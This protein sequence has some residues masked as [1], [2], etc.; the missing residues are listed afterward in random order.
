[1]EN[2]SSDNDRIPTQTIKTASHCRQTINKYHV[3]RIFPTPTLFQVYLFSPFGEKRQNVYE[4]HTVQIRKTKQ[5]TFNMAPN[6]TTFCPQR[7]KR[8][9]SA[10]TV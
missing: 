3:P 5:K 8:I 2:N 9:Q 1:M 7:D 6:G 4:F 10:I